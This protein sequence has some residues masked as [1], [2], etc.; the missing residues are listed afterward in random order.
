MTCLSLMLRLAAKSCLSSLLKNDCWMNLLSRVAS[1]TWLNM[2][3]LL[4]AGFPP[5]GLF[6]HPGDAESSVLDEEKSLESDLVGS[7]AFNGPSSRSA[8]DGWCGSLGGGGDKSVVVSGSWN[9][10]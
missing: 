9:S 4:D 5:F 10:G 8:V 6:S 7:D 2:V 3:L 1:W